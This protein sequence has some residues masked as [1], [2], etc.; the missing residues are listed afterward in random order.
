[1]NEELLAE[2]KNAA[3]I[4][5]DFLPDGIEVKS[6]SDIVDVKKHR[7]NYYVASRKVKTEEGFSISW[8]PI[9]N[10]VMEF[11]RNDL[12]DDGVNKPEMTRLVRFVSNLIPNWTGNIETKDLNNY[13]TFES[14]LRTVG[15]GAFTWRGD[16]SQYR[17][18][19][20]MASM[21]FVRNKRPVVN[22]RGVAGYDPK[23]KLF[24]FENGVV[25][26]KG[27][28]YRKDPKVDAT[29]IGDIYYRLASNDNDTD[30]AL[31]P[32]MNFDIQ[33]DGRTTF[34]EVVKL[35]GEL[36]GPVV[37]VY[38]GWMVAALFRSWWTDRGLQFPM[39]IMP[40]PP[41]AGK[42]SIIGMGYKL[43]GMPYRPT[44]LDGVTRT[45]LLS[46]VNSF[47]NIPIHID[48]Y[49]P[50]LENK[51]LEL[52]KGN[53]D[54]MSSRV[55]TLSTTRTKSRKHRT[56]IFIT[57]EFKSGDQALDS[58]CVAVPIRKREN[59][60]LFDRVLR[61]ANDL[62]AL[63]LKLL[64][65][66]AENYKFLD[67]LSQ[68]KLYQ[69]SKNKEMES[70]D[71]RVIRNYAIVFAA[72]SLVYGSETEDAEREA[73]FRTYML[74]KRETTEDNNVVVKMLRLI[75]QMVTGA[76]GRRYLVSYWVNAKKRRL[77]LATDALGLI[78]EYSHSPL[79][80][81]SDFIS[82]AKGSSMLVYG[83]P[84]SSQAAQVQYH[85]QSGEITKVRKCIIFDMSHPIVAEVAGELNA[86]NAREPDE[87]TTF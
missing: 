36:W 86:G 46:L 2:A 49:K 3:E 55:G 85:S 77:H 25:D 44:G 5:S 81:L 83:H 78:A 33:R 51:T 6:I 66:Y 40:A 84:D 14:Y 35:S 43:Y 68:A 47:C 69:W 74:S 19:Y 26:A 8:E 18:V 56:G 54:Q 30:N 64:K 22:V 12:Y 41:G 23:L 71:Q 60:E 53:A 50:T 82:Y 4:D 87:D 73:R 38:F 1:M 7:D 24:F 48:E 15:M 58:R 80:S 16:I 67:S 28:E 42:N 11:L 70:V 65:D 45:S 57:G 62:P 63:T 75:P 37:E 21:E 32:K 17:R 10:F 27:K 61:V 29:Q 76:R 9:S 72:L 13:Q 20:D 79:I 59:P 34:R 31:T 39:C 52:L